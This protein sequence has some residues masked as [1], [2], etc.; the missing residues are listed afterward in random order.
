MFSSAQMVYMMCGSMVARQPPMNMSQSGS[1][2][3]VA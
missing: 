2:A 3:W 1:S